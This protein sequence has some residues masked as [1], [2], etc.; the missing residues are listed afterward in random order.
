MTTME[1]NAGSAPKISNAQIIRRLLRYMAPFNRIM[2][3]S[4]I[5][6]VLKFSGQAAV[7][8]IAAAS[9]GVYINGYDPLETMSWGTMGTAIW[10]LI[11]FNE[12]TSTNWAIIGT[13]V[14]YIFW[15]GLLVLLR[16]AAAGTGSHRQVAVG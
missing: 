6:R 2:F 11:T 15:A 3:T 9:I 12:V 5:G 10:Q 13:Q 8:G 14:S 4:L 1:A 7:L 16:H